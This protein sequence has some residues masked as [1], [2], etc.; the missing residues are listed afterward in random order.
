MRCPNLEELPDPHGNKT[1]WPWTE[2]TPQLPDRTPDGSP[3]PRITIVT[4]SFNQGGFIEE[5]IRSVLLQGYPD[6]EYILI[7][8]G[9]SD[10]SLNIIQRYSPFLAYWV[11]EPD[12][13]Q[14]HAINKG[15][16]KATGQIHAYL[17]SDDLYEPGVLRTLVAQK[18]TLEHGKSFL[19]AGGCTFFEETGPTRIEKS[20]HPVKLIEF[21]NACPLIQPA[22]F[23]SGDLTLSEGGFDEKLSFCFD[24]EF[25]LRLVL[26]GIVPTIIPHEL[27]R[28]RYHRESKSK[29]RQNLYFEESILLTEK[30]WK[31][32]S[33]SYRE[34]ER[35]VEEM[36][37]RRRY[38]QTFIT[39]KKSGRF[40]AWGDFL[41]MLMR[42]PR[43][44]ARREILGLAHRLLSSQD[45][46]QQPASVAPE[47][48][49]QRL[50]GL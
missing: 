45:L 12:K 19:M 17:N 11:S 48:S 41:L 33:L 50:Y 42:Y 28:F 26:R 49:I 9:S 24:N 44:I 30:Y 10:D 5:T 37:K 13:G 25:F 8:G 43:L 6:L 46:R 1:G 27:A 38:L 15:L 3:W 32:A 16:A 7:D 22:T 2:E 39:W 36:D 14:S 31:S 4:P 18:V 23:W 34:K 20:Y 29:S 47:R 21:L 35:L 40:A